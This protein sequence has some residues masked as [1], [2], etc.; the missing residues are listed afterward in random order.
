MLTGQVRTAGRV[1][2]P[3]CRSSASSS[4]SSKAAFLQTSS[5]SSFPP[6]F[7]AKPVPESFA[8]SPALIRLS[9]SGWLR[10]TRTRTSTQGT[11]SRERR[12]RTSLRTARSRQSL[13]VPL[14][15]WSPRALSTLEK[16]NFCAFELTGYL[17]F[18]SRLSPQ[19]YTDLLDA[20]IDKLIA[21]K[22]V[23]AD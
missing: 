23:R 15:L 7:H 1:R 20:Q 6:L 3:T 19:S 22:D 9:M 17:P 8:D 18:F 12:A 16:F 2:S 4:L 11:R 5:R 21:G 14:S 10:W 13:Y